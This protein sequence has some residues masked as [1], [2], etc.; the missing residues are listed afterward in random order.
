[1]A[2]EAPP[3]EKK[4]S[5]IDDVIES[6]I[7]STGICQLLQAMLV[8]LA[9]VFDAQQTFANV[10]TDANPSWHCT[11]KND[12]SCLSAKSPCGLPRGSWSWNEPKHASIISEWSL[13]CSPPIIVGLPASAFYFGCLVGGLVLATADSRLG[14]KTMLVISCLVMSLAAGLAALSPNVW[15]YSVLRF[16]CGVARAT[17]GTSALVLSTEMVGKKYR[18]RISVMSFIFYSLGFLSLPGIAYLNRGLSWGN[19]YLWTSVPCFCYAILVYFLTCESPRWLFVRGRKDEAIST[20]KRIAKSKGHIIN[21]DFSNLSIPEEKFSVGML[22]ALNTLCKKRWAF[23][24]LTMVM[25]VGFGVGSVYYGMPL[26]VGNLGTNLYLS[27]A[28]NA[29]AELPSSLFFFF[30][31]DRISRRYTTLVLTLLSGVASIL[32]VFLT[33][34]GWQLA[35]E[36]LS[37]CTAVSVFNV[38]MI[39]TMELFPTSVRNSA[40]SL[41]RQALVLGGVFAPY[42]VAE[43]RKWRFLSFGVFGLAVGCCGMFAAFLPETRGSG[44]R[45]TIEEEECYEQIASFDINPRVCQ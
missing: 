43:G 5:S 16:F 28:Y 14:R 3:T 38:L 33:A 19:I 37:F 15:V 29:L 45:D 35:M 39:Y 8:V 32:C 44:M 31:M 36:V 22:S 4:T 1:M 20:L 24:R 41:V 10:F 9:W 42:I 40:V 17:V 2:D 25:T 30:F 11:N 27:V 34:R 21:V 26:N 12:S 23:K 13:Q 7:G 18:D 6:C